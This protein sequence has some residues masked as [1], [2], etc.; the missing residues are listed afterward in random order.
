M[1]RSVK[2]VHL[3]AISGENHAHMS[4]APLHL[5][6]RRESLAAIL[7]VIAF[8][9]SSF[10]EETCL[11]DLS[12]IPLDKTLPCRDGKPTSFFLEHNAKADFKDSSNYSVVRF[13]AFEFT[14]FDCS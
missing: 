8:K 4:I 2:T 1:G 12:A 10:L 6:R 14:R 5:H 13:P 9:E 7:L 3:S 11:T